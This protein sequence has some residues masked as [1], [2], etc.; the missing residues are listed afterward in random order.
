MY[1]I[2]PGFSNGVEGSAVVPAAPPPAINDS[3]T[4]IYAD[5]NFPLWQYDITFPVPGNGAAIT[6]TPD[7]TYIPPPPPINGSRGN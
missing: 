2:L 7:P 5:Y 4:S 1:G 3:I 6:L